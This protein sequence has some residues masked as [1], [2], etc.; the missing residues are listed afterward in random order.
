VHLGDIT[1]DGAHHPDELENARATFA[2]LPQPMRFLPGNHDIGDN[3]IAP[4]AANDHPLDPRRLADYRQLFGPDRWSL[5]AGAWQLIGLN[6]QLFASAAED[7]EEQFTWLENE[8]R[9]RRGP[10]G[11]LLHKPLFRDSPD[12]VEARS[13]YV[14]VAARQ[15]LLRL[16]A[17]RDLKF[18][19]S[20]H[21]HQSRRLHV[22]G[23]DHIWAP[24][25]A[26]CIPDAMQERIGDKIVG[27]LTLDFDEL[28]HRIECI[29]PTGVVQHSIHDQLRVYPELRAHAMSKAT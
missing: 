4:G 9:R 8:V 5:D 16:I 24:S 12:E 18:V 19:I 13:R 25:T 21:V 23:V 26:F 6:A 3:P 22:G 15:K 29:T 7:E 17:S 28:G 2:G 14:P 1:A 10:L 11:L 20:G 27:V